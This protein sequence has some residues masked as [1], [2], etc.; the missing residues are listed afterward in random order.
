MKAV[1]RSGKD[2]YIF[3]YAIDKKQTFDDLMV[4]IKAIKEN[5]S[6][7]NV[8]FYIMQRFLQQLQEINMI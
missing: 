5:P 1:W 2:G 7:K 8:K 4:D 6:Y 3:V